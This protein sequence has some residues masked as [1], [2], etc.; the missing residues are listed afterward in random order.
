MITGAIPQINHG[1]AVCN[2]TLG[3]LGSLI[4]RD[5]AQQCEQVGQEDPPLIAYGNISVF[6]FMAIGSDCLVYGLIALIA[7]A[8]A[9][10]EIR[11]RTEPIEE[12]LE[13]SSKPRA[14]PPSQL[15]NSSFQS[16]AE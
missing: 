8:R 11:R 9:V 2:S 16:I 1:I 7:E 3:R 12:S 15:P 4:F 5:R 10:E 6:A 14:I 13:Q